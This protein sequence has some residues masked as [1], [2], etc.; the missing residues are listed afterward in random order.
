MKTL[1]LTCHEQARFTQIRMFVGVLIILFVLSVNSCPL[2]DY[3][4]NP[5]CGDP[6]MSGDDCFKMYHEP[7]PSNCTGPEGNLFECVPSSVWGHY[8]MYY[9]ECAPD[10]ACDANDWIL[11]ISRD[12]NI[13]QATL[14]EPCS[15]WE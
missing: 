3:P 7:A 5:G 6:P 10:C 14:G 2:P 13:P 1:K 15:P 9:N 12:E 11:E 4:A 8:Y